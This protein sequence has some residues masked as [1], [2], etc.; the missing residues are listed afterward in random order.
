[1]RIAPLALVLALSCTVPYGHQLTPTPSGRPE[2]FVPDSDPAAVRAFVVEAMVAE[3]WAVKAE[4]PEN[5]TFRVEGSALRWSWQDTSYGKGSPQEALLWFTARD[6]G[7]HVQ[8]ARVTVQREGLES[9][10]L[11]DTSEGDADYE[12]WDR[13]LRTLPE[14]FAAERVA[15][16]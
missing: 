10:R 4:T 1:M 3:G 7:T 12:L 8:G 11:A 13:V 9:E 6:G 15:A 16:R 14:R 5:V 2:C